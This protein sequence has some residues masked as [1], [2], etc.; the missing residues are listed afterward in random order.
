VFDAEDSHGWA[1]VFKRP[2]AEI[3]ERPFDLCRGLDDKRAS[4]RTNAAGSQTPSSRAAIL[5]L[6]S[7]IRSPSDSSSTTSPRWMRQGFNAGAQAQAGVALD[8][9]LCISIAQRTRIR[10]RSGNR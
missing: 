5:D 6:P 1:I 7:P 2:S 3:D 8:M 9:P 10:P 4:D